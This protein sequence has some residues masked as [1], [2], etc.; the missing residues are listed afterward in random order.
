MKTLKDIDI[1][2]KTVLL[3][4]DYNVPLVDDKVGDDYRITQSLPTLRYLLEQDCRV[5]IISHLGR[6]EGKEDAR[7]SLSPIAG[8]LQEQL[9]EPVALAAD[10]EQVD[11]AKNRITLL[12]NLRFWPGEEANS[13]E[14]ARQ[15]SELGEVFVQDGFGVVHRSHASTEAITKFL[16][17]VAGLLLEK[18]VTSIT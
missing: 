7:Y 17:S 4:A 2:G 13:E 6:P 16:P 14:F 8:Y 10:F 3:R 15:L 11:S 5:V 1:R 9:G 12:E 18:E